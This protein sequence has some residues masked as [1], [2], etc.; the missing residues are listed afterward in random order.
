MKKILGIVALTLTFIACDN[1]VVF[2]DPSFNAKRLSTLTDTVVQP[3]YELWEASSFTA[4]E[5]NGGL[6]LTGSDS[7]TTLEIRTS[8][9]ISGAQYDMGLLEVNRARLITVDETGKQKGA[10]YETT[11]ELGSGYIKYRAKEKQ[12]PGTISAEFN[13]TLVNKANP[14]DTRTYSEGLIYRVKIEQAD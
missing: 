1:D 5:I 13:I 7:L 14:Q 8:S 2:K 3:T 6:I 10:I 11:D 9:F 12:E 4:K